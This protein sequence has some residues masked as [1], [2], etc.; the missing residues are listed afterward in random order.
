MKLK[1]R[2]IL[3]ILGVAGGIAAAG[4]VLDIVDPTLKYDA[5]GFFEQLIISPQKHRYSEDFKTNEFIDAL[6]KYYKLSDQ[7]ERSNGFKRWML[8]RKINAQWDR[9][10]TFDPIGFFETN[11][12]FKR[13]EAMEEIGF[14]YIPLIQNGDYGIIGKIVEQDTAVFRDQEY[15]IPYKKVVFM[16]HYY[17]G[18]GKEDIPKSNFRFNGRA[19]MDL[20]VIGAEER[21]FYNSCSRIKQK[22]PDKLD[23][24]ERLLYESCR[25]FSE[26]A[27]LEEDRFVNGAGET[28]G[29]AHK[30]FIPM[31]GR[32]GL[33]HHEPAHFISTSEKFAYTTQLAFAD[34]PL[35]QVYGLWQMQQFYPDMFSQWIKMKFLNTNNFE[36]RKEIFKTQPTVF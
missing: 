8:D 26:E 31:V 17:V 6:V 22:D 35:D 33:D 25:L 7:S 2:D 20:G 30:V 34:T 5:A 18:F 16:P 21:H 9:A 27:G 36:E 13:N 4:T 3:K 32:I 29:R 19:Y 11:N 12:S 24:D 23:I 28:D 15:N 1:R 14:L 10:R